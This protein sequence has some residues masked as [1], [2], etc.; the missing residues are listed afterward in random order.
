VGAAMP[1]ERIMVGEL[2]G[3]SVFERDVVW[4]KF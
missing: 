3:S 2:D 1:D 4:G